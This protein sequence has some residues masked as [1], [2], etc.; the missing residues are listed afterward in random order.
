MI[1]A[2]LKIGSRQR[3][4]H[5]IKKGQQV[6]TVYLSARLL[7]NVG[8]Q[9]RFSVTVSK[10]VASGAVERNHIRRRI[11]EALRLHISA[12]RP[13]CYDVVIAARESART[14]SYLQLKND[15]LT[16]LYTLQL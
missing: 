12:P 14:A 11:Y 16:L 3:V 10:R 8:A 2:K 5:V 9:N 13:P 4:E 7:T 6:K 1:S 15:V